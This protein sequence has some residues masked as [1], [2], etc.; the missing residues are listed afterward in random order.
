MGPQS[1]GDGAKGQTAQTRWADEIA[2]RENI[3]YGPTKSQCGTTSLTDH[4]RLRVEK[5]S[6]AIT[7]DRAVLDVVMNVFS[8][9]AAEYLPAP[10]QNTVELVSS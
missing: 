4:Q 1:R 5:C 9:N 7:K 3:T 2:V 6:A 10:I 8:G